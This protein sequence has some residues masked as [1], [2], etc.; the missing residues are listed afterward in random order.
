MEQPGRRK[1]REILGRDGEHTGT[2]AYLVSV[3]DQRDWSKGQ[4]EEE[5]WSRF[6]C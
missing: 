3:I 4:K 1:E 6:V 2:P 5:L